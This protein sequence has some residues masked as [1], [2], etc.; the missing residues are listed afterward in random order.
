MNIFY[1]PD[2]IAGQHCAVAESEL[3][4]L[5]VLRKKSGDEI[6]VFNGQGKLFCANLLSLSRNEALVMIKSIYAEESAKPLLHI[7]IAPPKNM[8]RMEWFAEK[9]CEIGVSEITPIFCEHSERKSLKSERL[10]KV[11]LAACKQSLKYTL[12]ILNPSLAFSDFIKKAPTTPERY[13]AY[14]EESNVHLKDAYKKG[15]DAVIVIGPEGD[16]SS[17]EVAEAKAH[18]YA[19]VSLGKSRLRLETAGIFAAGIFSLAND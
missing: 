1:A 15:S 13:I 3:Q 2:A 5:I 14:C 18:G 16:F 19:P 4:H 12:P 9:V 11:M 6:F 17:N 10:E 7:A 8:D